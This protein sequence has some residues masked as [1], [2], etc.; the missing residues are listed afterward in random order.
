MI[1]AVFLD[2]YGTLVKWSPDAEET[3]R[4]A[5][6]AE[7]VAVD[8]AAVR[9]AYPTAD[10]Y[11]NAENARTRIGSRSADERERFFAEY[12]R[13]LLSAAGYDVEPAQAGRI[14][15]RVQASQSKLAPFDDAVPALAVLREAGLKLGVI[16][17]MGRELGDVL[18]RLG[19]AKHL[20]FWISSEE[21]GVAKPHAA[22]FHAGLAKAGVRPGDALFVGDSYES[23][24][25]GA[26]AAGMHGVLVLR[27]IEAVAP[28]DC[29]VVRSLAGVLAHARGAAH[30]RSAAHRRS[31]A[32]K[33][34][35]AHRRSAD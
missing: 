33:R 12:E 26:Q 14:W 6:A 34:S 17:N 27:D 30:K 31:A 35:A 4:D 7:G 28:P 22:I 9:R 1:E 11:M 29:R 32:H 24:V 10:A 18:D 13:R 25:V 23:D 21:A 19:L 5:A 3:Q 16:S 8:P 15:S 20:D 2:F